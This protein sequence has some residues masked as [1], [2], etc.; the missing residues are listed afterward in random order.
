MQKVAKRSPRT[1]VRESGFASLFVRC[2]SGTKRPQSFTKKKLLNRS[3]L[4]L[5]LLLVSLGRSTNKY[6]FLFLLSQGLV[7]TVAVSLSL[8]AKKMASR[9]VNVKDLE[10]IETLGATS[11][12]CSD[13]TGT[14]TQN[15]MTVSHVFY[16]F[17]VPCTF[18]WT[19]VMR[20]SK[21]SA[22]THCSSIIKSI[23]YRA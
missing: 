19:G 5:K 20:N 4:N 1:L 6:V 21:E 14:L 22:F 7:A 12:I 16:D 13:K 3:I 2:S 23:T 10:S 17:K 8:T 15:I 11:A 9:N 18:D